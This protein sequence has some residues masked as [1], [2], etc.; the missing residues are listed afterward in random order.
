MPGAVEGV[1]GFG[2]VVATGEV[3]AGRALTGCAGA[4]ASGVAG[5]A[6]A[7][8]ATDALAAAGREEAG[9]AGVVDSGAAD[10]AGAETALGSS[11]GAPVE[12]SA[13]IRTPRARQA[14][15]TATA[16]ARP[17]RFVRARVEVPSSVSAEPRRTSLHPPAPDTAGGGSECGWLA[18]MRCMEIMARGPPKGSRSLASSVTF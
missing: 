16:I 14:A 7:D 13:T 5:A 12:R 18:V 11:V 1:A 4:P 15:P 9:V 10:V 3:V 2:D 17:A 8:C 6:L